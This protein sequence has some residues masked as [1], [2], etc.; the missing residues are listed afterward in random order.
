[1]R[2]IAGLSLFVIG[3]LASQGQFLLESTD[4]YPVIPYSADLS[5]GACVL[6]GYV[7][8]YRGSQD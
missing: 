8:A 1:M 4:V 7:F 6:G 2:I 5:C 3:T